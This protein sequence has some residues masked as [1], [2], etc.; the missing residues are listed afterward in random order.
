LRR[1]NKLRIPP[2][3]ILGRWNKFLDFIRNTYS[4]L[5][6][7]SNKHHDAALALTP[8][9]THPLHQPDRRLVSIEAHNQINFTYV[10]TLFSYTSRDESIIAPCLEF[11]HYL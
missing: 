2:F 1:T 8:S 4:M 9:A 7:F 3:S 6:A 10:Q 11:V 5:L